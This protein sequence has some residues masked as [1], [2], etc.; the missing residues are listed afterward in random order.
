M[1][2]PDLI[3]NGIERPV[4][5]LA[6]PDDESLWC[7]GL[8]VGTNL[9]WTIICCSIPPQDPERAWKF[10]NACS[11]LRAEPKLRP[12]GE[13][14]F[15]VSIA[16]LDL[17]EYDFILTHGAA[18]E[19]GH[20]HHIQL[21]EHIKERWPDKT[22]FIGYG[23]AGQFRYPLDE[24]SRILKRAA[25]ECYD[26]GPRPPQWKHLLANYGRKFDLWTERY[27]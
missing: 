11:V 8:I 7:A 25:I 5:V 26:G 6:H 4:A 1:A 13:E 24:Q 27:D 16:K 20:R 21:H 2:G 12:Y 19:Y 15:D 17:D 14:A 3:P 18:G 22:R 10:F 9:P 23:G